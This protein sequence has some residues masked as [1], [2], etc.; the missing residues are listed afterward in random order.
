[1]TRRAATGVIVVAAV[2]GLALMAW[3]VV[4]FTSNASSVK[5]SDYAS[6]AVA[7]ATLL[8]AAITGTLALFTWETLAS[9]RQEMKDT[10]EALKVAQDQARASS[11]QA[12]LAEETL[13][14]GWRPLLTEPLAATMLSPRAQQYTRVT[15]VPHRDQNFAFDIGLVNSGR[16]PAIVTNALFAMGSL[17]IPCVRFRPRIVPPNEVLVVTFEVDQ[18]PEN[19]ELIKAIAD[20]TG[21]F[22]FKVSVVYH[23]LG[24]I[25]AWRS[26]G[27]FARDGRSTTFEVVDVEI[28]PVPLE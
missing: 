9:A 23:D 26:L 28:T 15:I 2:I 11:E 27:R 24:P 5:A 14:A 6:M 17:N 21:T 25:R 4:G 1:M 7:G 16:G 13:L 20:T 8:L 22:D 18:R 10:A 19:Q 12:R 3:A